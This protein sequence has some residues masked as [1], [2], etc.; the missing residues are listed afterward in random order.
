MGVFG[1]G[2]NVKEIDNGKL[3]GKTY[4]AACDI[5]FT[6]E[7]RLLPQSF[8]FENDD[9]IIQSV[10]KIRLKSVE[11]K[12]YSGIPTKECSCEAKIDG[13]L[14]NFKLIFNMETCKWVMVD[15]N[16]G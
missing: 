15:R 11:N 6:S 13:I 1:I 3:S 4:K 5:W 16:A 10:E 12:N 2:T 9:G 14:K 8:K 7:G